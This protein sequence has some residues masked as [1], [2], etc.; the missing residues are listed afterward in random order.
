MS[1]RSTI[2]FKERHGGRSVAIIYRHSDGY[3]KG[4]GTDRKKTYGIP[5]PV[6]E[7]KDDDA[8]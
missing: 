5:R 7:G 6:E 8:K 4:A 2:H 1:T 3:P